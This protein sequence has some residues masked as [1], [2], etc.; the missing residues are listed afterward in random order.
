[1]YGRGR[2]A[3]QRVG[4]DGVRRGAGEDDNQDSEIRDLVE[5]GASGDF[6]G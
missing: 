4:A 3:A 1:M 6:S 5:T 2:C